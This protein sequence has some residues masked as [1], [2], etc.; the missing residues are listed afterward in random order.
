MVA[1]CYLFFLKKQYVWLPL[2]ALH[3][4]DMTQWIMIKDSTLVI[5]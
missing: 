2:A 3:K 4:N 1:F 5:C